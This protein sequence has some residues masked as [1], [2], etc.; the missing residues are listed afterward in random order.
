MQA[1]VG[2][3]LILVGLTFAVP[4]SP[5]FVEYTPEKDSNKPCTLP[6]GSTLPIGETV[7]P[8]PCMHCTCLI[9]G[10]DA[11][12]ATAMCALPLCELPHVVTYSKDHC[13]PYCAVP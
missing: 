10:W 13:C 9:A 3:T 4:R 8:D 2:L 5:L 1:V 12:C 11:A 6:D 7:Q